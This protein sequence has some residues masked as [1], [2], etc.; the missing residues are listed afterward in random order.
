LS[1]EPRRRLEALFPDDHPLYE[2]A[3]GFNILSFSE[4]TQSLDLAFQGDTLCLRWEFR[5]KDLSTR[6]KTLLSRDDVVRLITV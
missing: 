2:I 1:P 4:L 6:L 5:E 3:Q